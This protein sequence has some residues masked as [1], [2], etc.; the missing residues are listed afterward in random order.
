[1]PRYTTAQI[2][3]ALHEAHGM[4]FVAA[5]R[6]G[7]SRNTIKA[8]LEQSASLRETAELERGLA[9]DIAELKLFE[10][11]QRGDSWAVQFF[12]RTQ[13]RARGYSDR[14]E[15][16][17]RDSGPIEI[18]RPPVDDASALLLADVIADGLAHRRAVA[19]RD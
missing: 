14:Q 6:L 12:L 15:I 18:S 7:C 9:C 1:M 4:I 19:Q 11:V 10:S 17:G 8:R 16:V 13:A 2:D 5:K 3:A